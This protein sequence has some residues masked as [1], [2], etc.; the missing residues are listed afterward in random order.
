[1]TPFADYFGNRAVFFAIQEPIHRLTVTASR[2]SVDV[3]PL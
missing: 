3:A 2:V 1:M